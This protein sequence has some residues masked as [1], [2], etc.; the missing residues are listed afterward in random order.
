LR[1]DIAEAVMETI[2]KK[3]KLI[4]FLIF[5]I[6]SIPALILTNV[7]DRLGLN[8][9]DSLSAGDLNILKIGVMLFSLYA[10]IQPWF[11]ERFF[12]PRFRASSV[13]SRI[14]PEAKIL[15]MSYTMLYVPVILG[16]LLY[17][18]GLPIAQSNYFVGA[19]ILGAVVWCMYT[20]R[21]DSS[22]RDTTLTST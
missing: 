2:S 15:L 7:T 3:K 19:G 21:K 10:L 18:L 4:P 6:F 16:R 17:R 22:P 12:L 11:F 14:S 8:H 1:E 5:M 20:L 13:H 9:Y